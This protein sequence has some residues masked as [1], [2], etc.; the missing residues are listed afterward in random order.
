MPP[1]I[2]NVTGTAGKGPNFTISWDTDEPADSVVTFTC[3]GS[4]SDTALVTS[5]SMGF[6]GKG[7]YEYTVSSTDAAGNTTT[8]GPFNYPE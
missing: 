3:C 6:R 2:S 5:H 7:T 1:V 8:A 4:F